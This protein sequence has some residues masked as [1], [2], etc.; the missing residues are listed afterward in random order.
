MIDNVFVIMPAYNAGATLER[1]FERISP[2]ARE[3]IKRYIIVNDGSTDDTAQA[4][5]RVAA[6]FPDVDL[7][8]HPH[9]RGYG[10]AEKTLLN[11]AL[12]TGVEVAVLLHSDGQYSPEKIPRIL[13]VF[14]QGQA[15][16]VQGSR[17]LGGNA[18]S[19]MPFYKYVSN[20]LLTAVENLGFGLNMAEYHSGFMI[21]HRRFLEAV[22]YGKLSDYFDFDLEMIV[23]AK[24]LGFRIKEIPIPTIYDQE[25]SYLN[26]V[27]Y[28]LKVLDIVRRYRSGYYHRL[29]GA[30]PRG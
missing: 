4:M 20:K 16:L 1:V 6:S 27:K 9:N 24:V 28:G 15:D 18:F 10:G 30:K 2:E 14:D 3:R 23:A 25:I 12:E 26:P 21:Y 17:M 8:T 29:L 7:L 5:E 22:A 11:R 13:E 19:A